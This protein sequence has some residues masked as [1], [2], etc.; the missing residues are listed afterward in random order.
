MPPSRFHYCAAALSLLAFNTPAQAEDTDK[1]LG[2]VVVT[3]NRGNQARTIADSPSP[4]D[5]ISAEQLQASG[6]V[7]LKELLA[8]LLPSF[9]LPAINGG[10]T[11]WSVRGVTMRGLS[12]DQVLVL[13]NGKR[14]HNTAL[15]NN[16]ARIGTAAVPVNLDLIPVSAID[17]I[18]VLRDGASAQYGSDAIAGVINIILKENDSGGSAETSFGRYGAGDGDT[19]HQTVN[20]GLPLPNDGFANL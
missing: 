6:K 11:S 1:T 4:I 20:Y 15:I 14:R 10:G 19:V 3:G 16:L 2:T 5:V 12:G 8:R 18:E 13:V 9:N 7:G 17:H